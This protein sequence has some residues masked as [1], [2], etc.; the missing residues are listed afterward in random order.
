MSDAAVMAEAVLLPPV[1]AA[2]REP[3]AALP[4]GRALLGAAAGWA[5]AGLASGLGAPAP[6][7]AA[8][9]VPAGLVVVIGA[10]ALTG[11]ALVVGHQYL[12]LAARPVDLAAGLADGFVRSGRTALG[13][14]PALAFFALTTS[15]WLPMA[16]LAGGTAALV[17][18]GWA[19]S[20]LR[21]AE[22][23]S[24]RL[25][26]L[27]LGWSLLASLVALRLAI[28]TARMVLQ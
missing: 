25:D 16:V 6:D 1:V 17:A 21:R 14:A 11:P 2:R 26:G 23:P 24:L 5:C 22:A 12:G 19:V 20:G 7:M 8:R 13:F 9:A 15:L 4:G 27:A 3:A 28:D 10:M 18:L